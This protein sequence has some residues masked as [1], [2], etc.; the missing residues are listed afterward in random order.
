MT[1]LTLILTSLI[2]IL[3]AT[4]MPAGYAFGQ[5]LPPGPTPVS[6][7]RL[8]IPSMTG[9]FELVN[10]ILDFAP[11]AFAP[12]HTHGGPGLVTVLTG[13]MSNTVEG[14]P[15]Q[16]IKT[17]ENWAELPGEYALVGNKGT[18]NARV[19][20][21]VVLPKGEALT[22]VRQPAPEPVGMPRSGAGVGAVLPL[23]LLVPAL[24]LVSMGFLATR[25]RS[26]R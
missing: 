25:V 23:L 5:N 21:A 2:A 11:G 3:V 10:I 26:R 4:L 20:F 18:T 15:E 13:E 8:A 24:L 1:R 17:G 12:I 16:I 7:A 19:S 14:K 6:Q 22:T 9:E